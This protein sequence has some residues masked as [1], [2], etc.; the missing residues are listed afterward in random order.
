MPKK[1]VFKVCVLD[2]NGQIQARERVRASL[3]TWPKILLRKS[4][5]RG[6]SR[7]CRI[8][9]E[10]EGG[11]ARNLLKV[12]HE[13]LLQETVE[14]P[15]CLFS[16]PTS[17]TSSL[18]K[19]EKD[20]D[21]VFETGEQGSPILLNLQSDLQLGEGAFGTV[22]RA[23]NGQDHIALKVAH[24]KNPRCSVAALLET[25][26]HTKAAA[27]A[28]RRDVGS[29]LQHLHSAGLGHMD[30]KPGNWLVTNKC[31]GASGETQLALT[32]IDAGGAGRLKKDRVTSFTAEYSH[33]LQKGQGRFVQAFYDWYG[34][35]AS[36]FQLSSCSEDGVP[37]DDKV[38]AAASEA[39]AND[40]E[41][42]LQAVRQDGRALA[43][44]SETIRS[45]KEVV[46]EAVKQDGFLALS[47]ASETLRSDKE[48]V[49]EAV[50]LRGL[51]LSF[52][53]E[54]LRNGKEVV[55]EA[56]RQ[57]GNA[58]RF[59]SET[60]QSDKEV[61]L[62]AVR[63]KGFALGFASETLRSDKEMVMEAVRHYGRALQ[64]SGKT[65]RSDKQVV[66]RAVRQDGFALQFASETLRSDLMEAVRKYGE[67]L[68]FASETLRSDKE[69]VLEAVRQDGDAL[70][71]ASETLR[72][73]KE[74]VLEAVR[75]HGRVLEF[76]SETLRSDKKVV[77]EAVRQNGRALQFA[78]ETLRSDKEVVMEAVEQD[79]SALE[80][81]SETSSH[82]HQQSLS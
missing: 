67:A 21:I 4:S 77:L 65:L 37:K 79:G 2:I 60:L 71:F 3:E 10:K 52:A 54:T 33:P 18:V 73:D 81:A 12:Q 43:F 13:A 57:D 28:A 24:P 27:E 76:A 9:A 14:L 11:T 50:R 6:S 38:H 61:V 36:I 23:R 72:S 63:Q 42:T 8:C 55:M 32:L 74:V 64:Y 19:D 35:W 47:F 34:L 7:N 49:M 16:D 80:F 68:R 39:M 53:S 20:T 51:G 82:C 1:I 31:T 58:L 59:A 45:D 41:F 5:G 48:V 69:V 46:M 22:W 26:W 29:A 15:L 30:V 66:M 62:E 44:A 75:Q 25:G 17:G 56:V 70:R 40:K 78:S